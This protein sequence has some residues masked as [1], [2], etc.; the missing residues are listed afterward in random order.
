MFRRIVTA[1]RRFGTWLG[2][3][4]A[5]SVQEEDAYKAPEEVVAPDDFLGSLFDTDEEE[6]VPEIETLHGHILT[7]PLTNKTQL[8]WDVGTALDTGV[9]ISLWSKDPK[10]DNAMELVPIEDFWGWTA[11]M[12]SL[13]NGVGVI[14]LLPPDSDEWMFAYP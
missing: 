3:I 9:K 2:D 11:A 8:E 12:S 7:Q 13:G 6:E 5:G 14:F 1:R 10:E 4:V